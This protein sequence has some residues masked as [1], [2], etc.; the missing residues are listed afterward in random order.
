MRTPANRVWRVARLPAVDEPIT[1]ALFRLVEEK[2]PEPA[3]GE[4]LVRTLCLAPGPAQ[5]AYLTRSTLS[6]M[7]ERMRVGDVMRGRGVGQV[8][9]SRTPEFAEGDIVVASLGWQDYSVQRGRGADFVFSTR[10]IDPALR[11]YALALGTLG[12]AGITAY[13]GLLDAAGMREGDAVLVSAAAGGVGSVA[14]QVA[15]I[16]G[17]SR[18][19]GLAGTGE[20]CRWLTDELGFHAAINYR[21]AELGRRLAEE[22]PQGID[23]F[24]DNVGGTILDEGLAHLATGAR[25]LI[26][27]FI[28]TDYSATPQPG[29]S[30]YKN[31]LYK[32]ATM[33]GYVWFDYWSRYAEAEDALRGWHSAGVLHECEDFDEGLEKMPDSLASLFSGSNRGIKICR[34]APDPC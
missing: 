31:L 15:R 26:C 23:V 5:R 17:A 2:I 4:F 21:T 10:R 27:G 32:R 14:G 16:R 20:K 25:V 1:P 3:E 34:V 12:Q 19:V 22:F 7:T 13:F 9:R 30:N 11:P 24:F 28:S 6:G 8:I 33:R 18:V 29:P